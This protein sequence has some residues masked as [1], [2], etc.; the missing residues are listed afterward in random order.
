[1]QSN[2]HPYPLIPNLCKL[3]LGCCRN[4]LERIIGTHAGCLQLGNLRV[5]AIN[6]TPSIK[7]HGRLVVND[8]TSW[9]ISIP[10][11]PTT[12]LRRTTSR[13]YL[14]ALRH[15]VASASHIFAIG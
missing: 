3:F 4:A 10:S 11:P 15:E 7:S 9:F 1:V 5:E 2:Q 8:K 6:K 12:L 13:N 14:Q